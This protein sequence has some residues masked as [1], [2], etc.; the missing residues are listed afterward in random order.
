MDI[1]KPGNTILSCGER[2]GCGMCLEFGQWREIL[3]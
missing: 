2:K 3:N 1:C